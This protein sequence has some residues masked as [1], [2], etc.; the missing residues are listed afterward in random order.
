MVNSKFERIMKS[1]TLTSLNSKSWQNYV[2][3]TK[4]IENWCLVHDCGGYLQVVG[5]ADILDLCNTAHC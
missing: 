5:D 3:T 2:G 4:G 1:T